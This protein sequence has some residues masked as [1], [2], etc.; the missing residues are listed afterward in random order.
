[1]NYINTWSRILT[2][3]PFYGFVLRFC[4]KTLR[5]TAFDQMYQSGRWDFDDKT[6]ELIEIIEGYA[7]NGAILILGCGTA[8]IVRHLNQSTFQYLLGVDMS[9]VAISKASKQAN[10]KIHFEV[11]DIEEL[12]CQQAFDVILF[13]ESLYYL[14]TAKAETVLGRLQRDLRPGGCIIATFYDPKPYKDVIEMISGGFDVLK[15]GTFTGSNRYFLVF[16]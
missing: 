14:K 5:R 3:R 8:S 12:R 13:S 1:M 9:P 6:T 7:R 11:G 4:G 16:R 15:Q 10:T 2:F